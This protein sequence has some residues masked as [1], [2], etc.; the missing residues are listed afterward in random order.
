MSRFSVHTSPPLWRAD[1]DSCR[2]ACRIHR[3]CVDG[4]PIRKEKVTDSKIS[5][6]VLT[7]P[8]E[9]NVRMTHSGLLFAHSF[10]SMFRLN[11][12]RIQTF[13]MGGGGEGVGR[14]G[15]HLDF[16]IRG[17]RSQN[18]FRLFGPRFGLKKWGPGTFGPLPW[19]RHCKSG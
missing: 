13:R 14:I 4:S 9:M 16:E 1:S 2:F 12:W 3:V 7:G 10:L 17:A 18:F 8:Q 19:I 6:Y 15:S 11:Q 5:G